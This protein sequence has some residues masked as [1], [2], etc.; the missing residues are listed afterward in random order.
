MSLHRYKISKVVYVILLW[1]SLPVDIAFG[2]GLSDIL[3]RLMGTLG[4]VIAFGVMSGL[5][6]TLIYFVWLYQMEH[7]TNKKKK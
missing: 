3:G 5:L 4:S 2:I 6:G 1:V 7:L